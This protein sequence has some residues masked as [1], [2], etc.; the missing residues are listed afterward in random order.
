MIG[1]S[2]KA[3]IA[4]GRTAGLYTVWIDRERAWPGGPAPDLIA[5]N[6]TAAIDSLLTE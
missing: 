2:A 6:A 3:D 4:G 1:D 5:P